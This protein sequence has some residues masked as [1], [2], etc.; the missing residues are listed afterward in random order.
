MVGALKTSN[1]CILLEKV[2]PKE[3]NPALLGPIPQ[4][5]H[6]LPF[7]F[8]D[9]PYFDTT[10]LCEPIMTG[11]ISY[12]NNIG[13]NS[14]SDQEAWDAPL[15]RKNTISSKITAATQLPYN[16]FSQTDIIGVNCDVHIAN[17]PFSRDPSVPFN[18][19]KK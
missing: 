9:I 12:G 13:N 15:Q 16:Q 14:D 8:E 5:V 11:N 7:R 19:I 17:E 3:S 18:A 10:F 4:T 2:D 1:N 6:K